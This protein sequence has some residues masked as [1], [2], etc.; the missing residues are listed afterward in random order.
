[1]LGIAREKD[2]DDYSSGSIPTGN[3]ST[4][5]A[6]AI[7]LKDLSIGGYSHASHVEFDT[8]NACGSGALDDDAP[9]GIG[10]FTSGSGYDHDAAVGVAIGLSVRSPHNK[11][12]TVCTL[13]DDI[14]VYHDGSST[15]AGSGDKIFT[16]TCADTAYSGA[17]GWYKHT[18][19]VGGGIYITVSGGNATV[20]STYPC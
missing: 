16:D 20:T 2:F 6:V 13:A 12:G 14:D 15:Y 9:Y 5:D 7:S 3:P 18:D 1:M 11:F 10:E 19:P 8:N 17:S 4:G